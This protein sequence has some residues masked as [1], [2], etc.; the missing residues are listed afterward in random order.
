MTQ[1]VNNCTIS[2]RLGITCYHSVPSLFLLDQNCILRQ[3]VC[4]ICNLVMTLQ[5]VIFFFFFSDAD[6][7]TVPRIVTSEN[8]ILGMSVQGNRMIL[9]S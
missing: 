4:V 3:I 1:D 8:T 6:M 7:Y 9:N 5:R 2:P